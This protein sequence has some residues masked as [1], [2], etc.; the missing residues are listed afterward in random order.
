M[1]PTASKT[2]RLLNQIKLWLFPALVTILAGIIYKEVLEIRADVKILLAQSNV[3]KTKIEN[4]EN[5]VKML[6]N[7]VFL[8]KTTALEIKAVYPYDRF[9]KKE[10]F[11]DVNKYI[12]N[13]SDKL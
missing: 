11:F 8:K 12:T 13:E 9:F 1:S 4:L 5:E 3:D 10:E 7:A 6:N 2:D